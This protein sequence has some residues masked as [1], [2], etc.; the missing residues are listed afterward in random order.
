MAWKV[1]LEQLIYDS[2]HIDLGKKT[3]N[4]KKSVLI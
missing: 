1:L 4:S 3:R 2:P